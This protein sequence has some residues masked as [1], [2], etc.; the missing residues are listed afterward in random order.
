[1]RVA[2][3]WLAESPAAPWSRPAE[4]AEHPATRVVS[5]EATEGV[6]CK[7]FTYGPCD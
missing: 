2:A 4:P 7:A 3:D 1:M 6:E 5:R